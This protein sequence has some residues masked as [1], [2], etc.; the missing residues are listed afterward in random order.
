M[1]FKPTFVNFCFHYLHYICGRD[2]SL[3]HFFVSMFLAFS[4]DKAD[5]FLYNSFRYKTE[6]FI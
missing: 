2:V 3:P 6:V 1:T 5:L 4:I